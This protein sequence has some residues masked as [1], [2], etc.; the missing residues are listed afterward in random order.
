MIL[1]LIIPALSSCTTK[2]VGP[3]HLKIADLPF[4]SFTAFHIADEEG[5]FAEQGLEVE[6]VKFTSATQALPLLANGDLDVV[7]GSINAGLINAIAQNMGMKIVAGREYTTPDYDPMPLVVSR[8]LYENGSLDSVAELKGK[9]V[10]LHCTSCIGDF[11]LATFLDPVGLTLSDIT[12]VKMSPQDAV[13]AFENRAVDAILK[14]TSYEAELL[15]M[16]YGVTLQSFNKFKPDF[17][18]AFMMFGPT[19]L[20]DNPEAGKKFM[21]AYLKATR[22]YAEG[23]TADN[24]QV[25]KRYTGLDETLLQ[26]D[27]NPVD[28]NGKINVE[29][30]LTFQD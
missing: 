8:D 26:S 28:T 12:I 29:D 7:A 4:T 5:F 24:I 22:L 13:I 16:G 9:R 18:F 11:A 30:I 23:P 3:V 14:S 15:P 20:K 21:V 17:Q 25:A 27:W 2:E 1:V 6:F 10:V 19:L